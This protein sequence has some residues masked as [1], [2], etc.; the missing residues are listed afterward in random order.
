MGSRELGD[1]PSPE[2]RSALRRLETEARHASSPAAS[3]GSAAL[4]TPDL[5]GRDAAWREL[6]HAWQLVRG[7]NGVTLVV[8]AG[9]GLGKTFLCEQF[10]QDIEA[11]E[12]SLPLRAHGRPEYQDRGWHCARE[13]LAPLSRA[14]GL[15]GAADDALS[16]VSR[17]VPAIRTRYPHLP[18]PPEDDRALPGAVAEVLS[19]VAQEVPVVLFLDD[20]PN[21]DRPTA[22][23]ILSLARH[24]PP[25]TL[26]L[27]TARP[28]WVGPPGALPEL[29]QIPGVRR[30]KLPPLGVAEIETLLVSVIALPPEECR[31]LAPR[32]ETGGIRSSYRDRKRH[33]GRGGWR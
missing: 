33:G 18:A 15:G 9:E 13:L 6:D 29:Y 12:P 23:L 28:E 20:L 10:L 1:E 4:F 8:E 17:L 21:A 19:A 16:A 31:A 27:L 24:Q 2:F 5:V 32:P 26:L 22:D 25:G 30:L 7:G 3:P 11:R 14:P